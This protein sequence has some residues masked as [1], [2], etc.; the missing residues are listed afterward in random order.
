MLLTGFQR[1][2]RSSLDSRYAATVHS[3]LYAGK[4]TC[5]KINHPGQCSLFTLSC[6]QVFLHLDTVWLE[7]DNH[8]NHQQSRND[9]NSALQ[10]S[11]LAA[12]H[13]VMSSC[14]HAAICFLLMSLPDPALPDQGPDHPIPVPCRAIETS[15]TLYICSPSEKPRGL[16]NSLFETRIAMIQPRYM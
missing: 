9:C 6:G 12:P 4:L 13:L 10:T 14:L 7:D 5:P 8:T 11:T 16:N 1:S 3:R 2:T 15:C